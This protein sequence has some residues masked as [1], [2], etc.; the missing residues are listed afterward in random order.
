M[1][2]TV[3]VRAA[4]VSPYWTFW[5]ASAGGA[6]LREDRR[7]LLAEATA[8]LGA[9]LAAQQHGI[10]PTD[11]AAE[12]AGAASNGLELACAGLLDTPETAA[13]LADGVA[14]DLDVIVV[15]ICMAA[16]S[17][18]GLAFLDRFSGVPVVIWSLQRS[19]NIRAGFDAS[20]I[21]SAGTAVGTPQLT[22]MLARA[23]RPHEI[24]VG[25][26]HDASCH[27][28]LARAVRAAATASALGR[29]RIA[30]VGQP[31]AGYACV[32][33][34]AEALRR[35]TGIELVEVDP[36]ALR[37][38]IVT[39]PSE[40]T[41]RLA[42][43]AESAADIAAD[44]LADVPGDP[45]ASGLAASSAGRRS[46]AAAAALEALDDELGVAAG[47]MNC[48]V[49]ELRFGADVGIAPC[50]GL[51]RETSRGV[52]W[53]CAGDVLTAVAM[54]VGRRLGGA[55]LYHELEVIDF[56]TGEV[57]IANSGEHD[58]AWCPPGVRPRLQP[59][60]WYRDD[61]LTGASIWF[62]LP[63]GPASLIGFTPHAAEPSGYRFVVAE[64]HITERSLPQSPTVGGTFR[65]AGDAGV[66]ES[67]RAWAAAGVNHHS[68][69]SPGHLAADVATVAR[70]LKVGCAQ[71]S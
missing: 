65:F 61:P 29:A 44:L 31:P 68:A 14:G 4:V 15:V 17:T 5:E 54:L 63:P 2:P 48:H 39:V 38:R 19:R 26:L 71:V 3:P 43:E 69:A 64:G 46:L 20:D 23:G 21:T 56:D 50:Y 67:W 9:A 47:A 52:P 10:P 28:R 24:V 8:A 53:T 7:T 41:E 32:D 66:G 36:A 40:V 6:G 34:D 62:E 57:A 45:G 25:A 12:A 42:A 27:R 35:A 13:A 30:R 51:G 33:T 59:N 18:H 60:P 11:G 49:P 16:P 37:R 58:L 55:A 22:N 70:Y 1:S